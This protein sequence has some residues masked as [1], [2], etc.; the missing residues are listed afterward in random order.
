MSIL[1]IADIVGIA[2]F[3]LSGFWVAVE[4][5]LDLLGVFIASFLTALGGGIIRDVIVGRLPYSFIHSI[6]SLLVILVILIAFLLR[7]KDNKDFQNRSIF[8]LSDSMGLV[9]FSISG[10]LVG[11]ESGL[12]FFGVILLSLITAVGGG[13]LRDILLNRVPLIL[14]SDIYGSIAII[15]GSIIYIFDLFN[16]LNNFIIISVFILSLL[17]RLTAYYK[18]WHLPKVY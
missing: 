7:L 3:A 18:N 17:L 14:K 6:P 10:A 4:E 5:K 13:V 1:E 9:S 12:E 2:A 11:L 15:T 16:L 8:I